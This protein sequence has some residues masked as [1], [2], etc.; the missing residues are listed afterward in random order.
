MKELR[1]AIKKRLDER[2]KQAQSAGDYRDWDGA[3]AAAEAISELNWVLRQMETA[4]G[5]LEI[6]TTRV[7]KESVKFEQDA[8]FDGD[9]YVVG[10]MTINGKLT[11]IGFNVE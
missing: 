9:V 1:E 3:T 10:N 2:R 4:E 7:F 6:D 8:T 5:A 11:C